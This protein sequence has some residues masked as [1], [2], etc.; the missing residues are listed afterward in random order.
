MRCACHVSLNVRPLSH[1]KGRALSKHTI[2]RQALV[3]KGTVQP[4]LGKMYAPDLMFIMYEAGA[5]RCLVL[6]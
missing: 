3:L 1:S 5:S 6:L 2:N 4:F